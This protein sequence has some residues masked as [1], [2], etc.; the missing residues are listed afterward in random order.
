MSSEWTRL[1]GTAGNPGLGTA[2][3]EHLFGLRSGRAVSNRIAAMARAAGLGNGFSGHSP[4]VG[5]AQDLAANGAS[6]TELMGAG[7]WTACRMPASLH[8]GA[9]RWPRRRGS[10]LP[11]S[12]SLPPLGSLTFVPGSE[13]AGKRTRLVDGKPQVDRSLSPATLR[14]YALAFG[15]LF[16]RW[17]EQR[18]GA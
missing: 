9:G 14:V 10:L 6:T 18:G 12:S 16:T 8:E 2:P 3:S 13:R 17:C 15:A 7:R 11:A 4:R 1:V 5:M